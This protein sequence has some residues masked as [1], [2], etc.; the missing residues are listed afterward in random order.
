[1]I[2]QDRKDAGQQ[3]VFK[4]QEYKNNPNAIVLAL[5]RGGI[6]L[7]YEIA[8]ELKLPL[9]VIIAQKIGAPNFQELAIGAISEDGQTYFDA[10][11]IS[12]YNVGKEYLERESAKKKKEAIRRASL[13]RKNL[14]SLNLQNKIAILVDDGIATGATM[15]AAIKSAKAKK[16]KKVIAAV[17]V[18]AFDTLQKIEKEADKVIYLD[19]PQYFSAVGLF[20]ENFEQI[21]DDEV[22]ELLEKF[23][24]NKK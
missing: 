3:L 22:V 8:K 21:E 23:N 2:F 18:I 17:P 12:S 15:L 10:G 6:I 24:K 13:Y 14:P 9:D 7:A 5:P 4:L 16:A 1:M 20:Y 19:A 11:I